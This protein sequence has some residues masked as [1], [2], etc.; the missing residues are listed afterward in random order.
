MSDLSSSASD[1]SA[2]HGSQV[3]QTLLSVL[4]RPAIAVAV[5]IIDGASIPDDTP[6]AQVRLLDLRLLLFAFRFFAFD[7]PTP[8]SRPRAV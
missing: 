8:F 2:H 5:Q 7:F 1:P 4:L 6:V 3:A